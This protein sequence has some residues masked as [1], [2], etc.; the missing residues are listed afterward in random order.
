MTETVTVKAEVPMDRQEVYRILQRLSELERHRKPFEPVLRYRPPSVERPDYKGLSDQETK[1]FE[2]AMEILLCSGIGRAADQLKFDGWQE[3]SSPDLIERIEITRA[4]HRFNAR[5]YERDI[6]GHDPESQMRRFQHIRS[7]YGAWA[8]PMSGLP[9]HFQYRIHIHPNCDEAL[10][11]TAGGD[12]VAIFLGRRYVPAALIGLQCEFIKTR[13]TSPD[14]EQSSSY[15]VERGGKKI[16]GSLQRHARD[17][18]DDYRFEARVGD[19]IFLPSA[20]DSIREQFFD[21]FAEMHAL[22][23][24]V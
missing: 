21:V 13:F 6:P 10:I 2:S 7:I 15:S 9:P 19:N 17:T 12:C 14:S 11:Q 1:V 23:R 16:S 4:I 5:F 20:F 24:S 3:T 18:F 22:M 8:E